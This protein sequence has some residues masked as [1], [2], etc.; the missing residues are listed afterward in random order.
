VDGRDN[1]PSGGEKRQCTLWWREEI[2]Y[3]VVDG[4]DNVPHGG[5]KR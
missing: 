4:R 2:M 5:G 1:V 3:L